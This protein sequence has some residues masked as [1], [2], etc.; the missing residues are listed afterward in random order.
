[1]WLAL[2]HQPKAEA[3]QGGG[4][5]NNRARWIAVSGGVDMTVPG[6]AGGVGMRGANLVAAG[7]ATSGY[8]VTVEVPSVARMFP[9]RIAAMVALLLVW[10]AAVGYAW[11]QRYLEVRPPRVVPIDVYAAFVDSR[12]VTVTFGAGDQLISWHTTADDVRH[13]LILWRRMHLADW[14]KV[15]E[16]IRQ[17]ALDNML[18]R[19]RSVLMNP[20]AWDT[21]D[22]HDWDRVPQ[23]MRTI[24]YRQMVA[25]WSGYYDV[26][27]RHGLPPRLVADTLAAMVMSESWFD[28]R[29]HYTNGDASRDIGLGGASEFA[30][31]RLRQLHARGIVDVGLSDS[32]Y[33]NP[34]KA[35]RFVAIWMSLLLDE[36]DG[37]L[38]LAIRAYNRGI[39][40]ARDAR[41]TAYLEMVNRRFR[42]FI[43]NENA[44]AAWDYVWRRARELERQEWPW[45]SRRAAGHTRQIPAKSRCRST[46]SPALTRAVGGR[47]SVCFDSDA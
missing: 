28:H 29:G 13:N 19:H 31:N 18:E 16:P 25:Y 39:R 6:T 22:E 38:D 17:Q 3:F 43:R 37:D 2:N 45:M 8:P 1:M 12:P 14:N 23:P 32:D 34:W 7:I 20:S 21:M 26:G 44:P 4:G 10:C 30:R 9:L 5:F 35:T 11:L 40:D 47:P 15:P 41:G 33:F 46:S 42:Q 27:G 24:A 36:A